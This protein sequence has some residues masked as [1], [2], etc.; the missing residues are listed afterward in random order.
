YGLDGAGPDGATLFAL[1]PHQRTALVATSTGPE[2]GTY[3]TV[4]GRMSLRA[5][6]GFEVAYPF[7][8]VLPALPVLPDTDAEALRRRVGTDAAARSGARDT[9]WVGKELGRLAPLRGLATQL[10]LAAD[11]DALATRLRT[12]LESWFDARFDP[13]DP[14]TGGS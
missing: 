5:G 3:T 10:G 4:R 9:Y 14:A 1:Y 12:T 13:A 8:G 7:P 6:T 11:A 2:L